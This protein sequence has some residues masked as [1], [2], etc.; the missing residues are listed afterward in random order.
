MENTWGLFPIEPGH[1]KTISI[2]DLEARIVGVNEGLR[3]H[4]DGRAIQTTAESSGWREMLL[5]QGHA[6]RL[7]P[8]TPDLPVV[9]RVD[10]PVVIAVNARLSFEVLLPLWLEI[11]HAKAHPRR[12]ISGVLLDLPT[13]LL[14]RSWFGTPESG[15]VAYS[16]RINPRSQ[17][18][19]QR[20]LVSVSVSIVN[21]STTVLR[22]ERFLLRAVHLGVYKRGSILETNGVDVAFK[23][24]EQLSQI[25][26]ETHEHITQRGG[27]VLLGPPREQS[28]NDMI[29]KSFGWLREL[30]V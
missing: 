9:L 27:G 29:R 22:F 28:G 11:G 5:P 3:V 2:G 21:R 23:G 15:E 20:H 14:K 18:A 10:E 30:A 19:Y 13:K 12:D 25:T 16:W 6:V 17:R 1:D 7:R 26:F 8:R 24:N 4:I